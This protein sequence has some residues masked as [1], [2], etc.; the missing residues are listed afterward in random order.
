MSKK[1]RYPHFSNFQIILLAFLALIIVG[2]LFLMLPISSKEGVVTPFADALFTSTSAVCVTGLVV[3]DTATYWSFF[4]KCVITLLIQCGGMGIVTVY[5]VVATLMAKKIGLK[6]RSVMQESVSAFRV[7]GVVGFARFILKTV[8]ICELTGAILLLPRFCKDFGI[9]KGV[10]YALFH[11][12]SAFCNAGFDLM[13]EKERFSSLT[14]Y[15]TSLSVNTV[16]PLLILIG[17]LGFATISDIIHNKFIFKS[18][19][20]QTKLILVTTL[21]LVLL[22]FVYFYTCEFTDMP[23]K[24]R[25]LASFFQ[26]VTPRTA[27]FN[28]A[29][30]TKLSEG[31]ITVTIV[32]ML[33]GGATASTAGGIKTTTVAVLTVS[34]ISV[35]LRKQDAVAFKRR[36]PTETVDSASAIMVMYLVLFL[37]AGVVISRIEGLPLM[38][39]MFESASAIATVGL[40]LGITTRL[41]LISRCILMFLMFFG[42]VGGLTIIF[43]AVSGA[44][45]TGAKLPLDNVSVG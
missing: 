35:F 5:M 31:G 41:C 26:T 44:E 21:L 43:A 37:T 29:D 2:A 9:L 40:T 6:Q 8:I 28:T 16:I 45:R 13:G 25:I 30:L 27:G 17:G 11:S 7:G 19:A 33:I 32:L 4:G 15:S 23:L 34:A 1:K 10:G 42:R 24:E 12:V 3:Y 18:F 39:C 14:A 38:E 36:I 20:L 22:P